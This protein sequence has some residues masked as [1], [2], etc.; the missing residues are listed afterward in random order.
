MNEEKALMKRDMKKCNSQ[1]I[2]KKVLQELQDTA[3]QKVNQE[4][5]LCTTIPLTNITEE[6]SNNKNPLLLSTYLTHGYALRS[7]EKKKYFDTY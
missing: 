1:G 4:T 5:I 7:K 6:K 2:P 3:I